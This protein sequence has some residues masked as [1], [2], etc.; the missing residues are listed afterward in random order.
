MRDSVKIT[1]KYQF[2][3]MIARHFISVLIC[4]VFEAVAFYAFLTGS[5]GKYIVSGIFTIVYG[6]LMYSSSV[7]LSEF[8]A[9]PYTPLKPDLKYGILWGAA[10]SGILLVCVVI[11]KINWIAF[12]TD[13]GLSTLFSVTVNFIFYIVTAPFY[14]FIVNDS[15]NIPIYGIALMVVVP[16][17]ACGVGYLAGINRF[18]LLQKL[19]DMTFEK[20]DEE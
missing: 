8:D 13:N 6:L 16:I 7:K 10:V 5:P 12:G 15:G 9:R 2:G 18:D 17:A 3:Y 4:L 14:G 20:N 11:Y 1:R 19:D